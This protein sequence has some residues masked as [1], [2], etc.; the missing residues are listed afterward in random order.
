MKYLKRFNEKRET[1]LCVIVNNL[2]E[3]NELKSI[4]EPLD[5][6][7]FLPDSINTFFEKNGSLY[8]YLHS[9][10]KEKYAWIHAKKKWPD[11]IHLDM[12]DGDTEGIMSII[13]GG[14]LGLL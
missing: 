8:V 14:K 1:Q 11:A 3:L 7:L 6:K 9:D 12:A 10:D 5:Y 4:L 2:D 13:E